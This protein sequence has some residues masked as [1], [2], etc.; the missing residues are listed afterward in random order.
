MPRKHIQAKDHQTILNKHLLDILKL[1]TEQ[2][3][4][5]ILLRAVSVQLKIERSPRIPEFRSGRNQHT[6]GRSR[7]DKN[8]ADATPDFNRTRGKPPP[9]IRGS[10]PSTV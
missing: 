1:V 9:V 6:N 5:H 7:G 2:K 4:Q 8:R 10:V 3:Q